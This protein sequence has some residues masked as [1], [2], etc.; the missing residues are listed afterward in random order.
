MDKETVEIMEVIQW[1]KDEES[2]NQSE[3]RK[4]C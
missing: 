2:F 4:L 3:K 1:L